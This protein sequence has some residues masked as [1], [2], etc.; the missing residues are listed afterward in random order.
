LIDE[1]FAGPR[2]L[3]WAGIEVVDVAAMTSLPR[4]YW[5]PWLEDADVLLVGGGNPYY[6]SYW[7][8]QSGVFADLPGLLPDK[9]YVGISAGSMMA[10]GGL[11]ADQD[12]YNVKGQPLGK[13]L[14][15][16]APVGQGSDK[17]L[18]FIP[19]TYRPHYNQPDNPQ[20]QT[21]A[22]QNLATAIGQPIYACDDD[23][24]L[25]VVDGDIEVISEGKWE[26]LRP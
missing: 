4:S 3:G 15:Q 25:K 13:S 26:L 2:S 21:A 10:G 22:I 11:Q 12:Y 14:D 9:L 8:Q 24:A 6:L 17:T 5:W 19:Q 23:T 18:G 20:L 1:T 7:L 16:L